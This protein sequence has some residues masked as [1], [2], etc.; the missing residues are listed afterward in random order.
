[1]ITTEKIAD[2]V[3]AD[4]DLITIKDGSGR[5]NPHSQSCFF[6]WEHRGN[7]NSGVM[8]QI[9]DNPLPDEFPD[10]A[11]YYIQAKVNQ[12]EQMPDGS[13]SY[14][15]K[16]MDGVGDA[17]CYNYELNRYVWRVGSDYIF[18]VAFNLYASENEQLKWAKAIGNE[19]MKNF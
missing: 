17:G 3:G 7:P 9:Q 5:S 18:M 14:K 16:T 4:A 19:V 12:G 1:M 2:I 13:A 8:I 15:Y 11:K 10:W 6:R